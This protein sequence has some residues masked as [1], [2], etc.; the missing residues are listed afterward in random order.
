MYKPAPG[1][2]AEQERGVQELTG[3]LAILLLSELTPFG[4][5]VDFI[6]AEAA[7]PEFGYGLRRSKISRR[8]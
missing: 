3:R 4:A 1:L 7:G 8:P 6:G 2:A 5:L